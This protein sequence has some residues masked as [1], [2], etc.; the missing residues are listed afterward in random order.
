MTSQRKGNTGGRQRRDTA[1][2]EASC[3]MPSDEYKGEARDERLQGP[4]TVLKKEREHVRKKMLAEARDKCHETR[5]AYVEC[6]K[7][8]RVRVAQR[9]ATRCTSSRPS[10]AF[11]LFFAPPS[12]WQGARSAYHSSAAP[13]SRSS[14]RALGNSAHATLFVLCSRRTSRAT[15]VLTAYRADTSCTA[16]LCAFLFQHDRGGARQAGRRVPGQ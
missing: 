2:D 10:G 16:C 14:M 4:M 8:E 15:A 3:T 5:A 11:I 13:S 7:G 6:A 9:R 12:A 1:R